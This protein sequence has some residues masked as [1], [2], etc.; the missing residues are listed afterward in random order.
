MK[1][2]KHQTILRLFP[3]FLEFFHGCP[4]MSQLSRAARRNVTRG[5]EEPRRRLRWPSEGFIRNY[6]MIWVVEI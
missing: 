5:P 3:S 2:E 4:S 1:L 6:P